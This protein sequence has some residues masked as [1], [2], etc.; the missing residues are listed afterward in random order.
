MSQQP[1]VS[2]ERGAEGGTRMCGVVSVTVKLPTAGEG[3]A[4]PASPV[5]AEVL[6][7]DCSASMGHPR[8]KLWAAQDAA[9]EAVGALPDGTYFAIVAGRHTAELLYPPP[10]RPDA[11]AL[12]RADATTRKEAQDVVA[13]LVPSG[14]TA[15]GSWLALARRLFVSR[16]GPAVRHALLLSD[17]R[18]EHE[19]PAALAGELAA[20]SGLFTCDTIGVGEDWD[21]DE[22]QLV[23]DGLDGRADAVRD[24]DA[25]PGEFRAVT[26]ESTG[27]HLTGLRLR[28]THRPGSDP[29]T[30]QQVHP[31]RRDLLPERMRAGER[32]LEFRTPPWGD[33]TREYLVCVAAARTPREPVDRALWLA[34]LKVV[35]EPSQDDATPEPLLPP[36][37]PLLVHWTHH[38]DLYSTY[39]PKVA[40][41]AHHDALVRG[42]E[43]GRAAQR[44]GD[45]AGARAAWGEAVRRA[46]AMGNEPMLQRLGDV[47]RIIDAAAGHVEI[48]PDIRP[49][50]IKSAMV[51]RSQSTMLPRPA[52]PAAQPEAQPEPTSGPLPGRE[53]QDGE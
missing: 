31:T 1:Y 5:R 50:D 47:V 11:P 30:V 41:Y 9:A 19:Q 27:R 43:E 29:L 23:A 34:D 53:P 33:E 2:V 8:E 45:A 35:R 12:V 51:L 52:K 24:L 28:L 18:N 6:L 22:L 44:A 42:L 40:H 21:P 17:G 49:L 48:R 26:A 20:C 13:R 32:C 37:R 46:H 4:A 15:I 36:A 10:S 14:G 38:R 7:L 25:L 16:P 3:A 39:D